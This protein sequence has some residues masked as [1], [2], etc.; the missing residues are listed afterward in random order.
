MVQ[1]QVKSD[2]AGCVTSIYTRA[3][4]GSACS[5]H[6]VRMKLLNV[7]SAETGQQFSAP[8][9][10]SGLRLLFFH[11]LPFFPE[12]DLTSATDF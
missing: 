11:V 9:A 7:A 6:A 1:V 10:P 4:R 3:K 12:M 8:L 5:P 2:E